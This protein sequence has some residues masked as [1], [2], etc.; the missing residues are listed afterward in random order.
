MK[1]KGERLYYIAI[2]KESLKNTH[3]PIV[4]L[5]QERVSSHLTLEHLTEVAGFASSYPRL[6]ERGRPLQ[7]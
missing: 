5:G 4:D 7:V 1:N 2:L 3:I 6:L